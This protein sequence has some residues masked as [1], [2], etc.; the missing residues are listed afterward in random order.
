[1]KGV[2][3]YAAPEDEAPPVSLSLAQ[4]G[5]HAIYVGVNYHRSREQTGDSTT[6]FVRVKLE[7]DGSYV[8]IG[9]EVLMLTAKDVYPS[10]MGILRE[11]EMLQKV[12]NGIY[13]VCW[14]AA[15][16]DNEKIIIDFEP[17]SRRVYLFEDKSIYEILIKIGIPIRS[18]CGGSGKCGKCKILFQKGQKYL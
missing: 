1:M 17:I 7:S 10:K 14:K 2:T 11:F 6:G 4:G 15:D 16:L 13:E 8:K 5:W 18:L 3:M 9:S 12:W